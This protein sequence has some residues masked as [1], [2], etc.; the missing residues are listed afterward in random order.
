LRNAGI[1]QLVVAGVVT[2]NSVEATVRM[3]GNLGFDTLLVED[4]CFA[5]AKADLHG[6]VYPAEQV[7]AL[8]LANMD[9]EY[10]RVVTSDSLL[11]AVAKA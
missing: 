9:G 4:A 2:N 8:S 3:A 1:A 10:C 5:F 6:A 11:A 7:H